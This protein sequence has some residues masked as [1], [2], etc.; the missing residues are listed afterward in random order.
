M[1]IP[2]NA[3]MTIRV[4]VLSA[5][6]LAELRAVEVQSHKTAMGVGAI[7]RQAQW[8]IPYLS[9]WGNQVQ[10]AGRQLIYNFTL[11]IALAIG[12]ATKFA[13]ENEKAM[14]R[15]IKVYGDG[16]KQFNKLSK[17][18]LPALADAFQALSNQFGVHQKEVLNIAGDWAAAGA[19]GIALAK[20]VKLTLE[21]MV[22]GEISAA[23]A[24]ENLIA[25][26][27]Q[28][29]QNTKELTNTID[30]LNMVENQTGA[31]MKG[32]MQAF[33]RSAGVARTAGVDVRHLGAMIAALVPATGSAATAGNGLK[34]MISRILSPTQEG[35][36]VM[37]EMGVQVDQLGWQSLNGTQRLEKMAE[38]FED[39]SDAQ[40]VHVSTV[41]ASRWQINRFATLMRDITNE[42]GYYQRSL[43]ATA[44]A[45]T[46]FNQRQFE[47]RKVLE[48]NPQRMQQAW[49][50]IKNAMADVIVPLL[51]FITYLA[52]EVARLANWFAN[53]DG[54]VQKFILVGFVFLALIGPIARYVGSVANLI[55][56]LSAAFHF[57]GAK[58][59]FML[60]PF[61]LF[62]K[63]VTSLGGPLKALPMLFAKS[64]GALINVFA[65][66]FTGMAF[67]KPWTM[68]WARITVVT[69]A[70]MAAIKKVMLAAVA[71]LRATMLAAWRGL[72]NPIIFA[73]A[74]MTQRLVWL[75]KLFQAAVL[76][77]F[78]GFRTVMIA[79]LMSFSAGLRAGFAAVQTAIGIGWVA[80][81]RSLVAAQAAAAMAIRVIHVGML[82]SG[83]ALVTGLTGVANA[84]LLIT[85]RA[86]IASLV[87]F[88]KI[89]ALIFMLWK[90]LGV[91][92]LRLA[93]FLLRALTGPWGLAI[94]AI[95]G[96]AY[97]FRDKIAAAW[98]SILEVFR[99][100][101][102]NVPAFF[103]PVIDFFNNMAG[104]I[105][106][107]FWALPEGVR[108]AL[109]A[110]LNIVKAAAVQIYE[111]MSYL[112]PFARHSPSLVESVTSGMD[113]IERQFAR[114]SSIGS[115]FR[116]AA[117][118]LMQFKREA[119]RGGEFADER[120]QVKQ[121]RGNVGLFDRLYVD[122]K[123]L[124]PIMQR[125]EMMVS[126][127]EAVVKRWEGAL[128]KAN[129]A[130]DRQ[131]AK[132][133]RLQ[134]H[135][136]KLQNQ[137]D[138]HKQSL[139]DFAN[140]PIK[141]MRAMENQIFA[142]ELAQKKLRLELLRYEEANGSVDDLR[143]RLDLLYG[144][145]ELLR[146]NAASLRSAGAGSD[147]LGPITSQI[148][149]MEAQAAALTKTINNNPVNDLQKQLEEL[150]LQGEIMDLEKSIKFDP[151][152]HE[153]DKLV[154]SQ[155]ELT[156]DQIIKG[157]NREQA[158]MDALQ[159]AIN[160]ATIAVNKQKNAVDQATAARDRIQKRYDTE[161]DK[162]DKL[163]ESYRQTESMV[164]DIE[165]ALRDM[166]SA[167][168]DAISKASGLGGG[169][170]P[171]GVQTFRAG[172]GADFADPGRFAQ[173][174]REGGMGNQADLINQFTEDTLGE[175]NSIF[176][177]FDMFGPIKRWWS[178]T[179][180]WLKENV[181]PVVGVVGDAI[182][183][184]WQQTVAGFNNVDWTP[185]TDT[186]KNVWNTVADIVRTGWGWIKAVID[187][188]APD[189]KRIFDA[190]IEAGKRLWEKLGPEL[191]KF[192]E[193]WEPLSIAI[194]NLW[195]ILKPVI[196]LFGIALV[197]AFKLVASVISHTLGP[198]LDF[199]VDMFVAVVRILRGVL[200]FII[201]VFAGD[202]KLA[203][204]GI[205]NIFGGIWDAIIATL[206]GAGKTLWGIVKGVVIGIWEFF[207]WL[208]RILVG[209][210]V[211]WDIVNGIFKAFN[212]LMKLPKWVWDNV[213]KPVWD[214][215]V[216][217]WRAIRDWFRTNGDIILGPIKTVVNAVIDA[218]NAMI[219]GMN[220][221]SDVLPGIDW[222]INLIP[223][224]AAGGELMSR[225][226]NRGFKTSGARAIVG[227][228]KANH[229]E[230]VIPTDPTHRQRALGL[231]SE[232]GKRMGVFDLPAFAGGGILDSIRGAVGTAKHLASE[233][234]DWIKGKVEN[235]ASV[236][237][238]FF[239]GQARKYIEQID[240]T[241][242]RKL[243]NFT[244]DEV[245]RWVTGADKVYADAANKVSPEVIAGKITK[246][247]WAHPL[248]G[249]YMIGGS[250]GSYPGHTG[251]DLAARLGTPV[252]AIQS[253]V[254]R[255]SQDLPGSN[256]YNSTPYRSYGRYIQVGHADGFL[257]L[258][259]HLNSRSV[260]PGQSVASGA[261]L[262]YVGTTGNST[263]P[264]LHLE[265]TK[266]G[267]LIE[268][269]NFLRNVGIPLST[270]GVIRRTS[271]GVL[272][273]LGEGHN[274]EVVAPL[275]RNWR[276]NGFGSSVN[277]D[278]YHI[279][280][281]GNLEFPNI[282]DGSDAE[283]FIENLIILAK[284]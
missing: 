188:F 149:A 57:L 200:Q 272:T 25:I 72:I 196:A 80:F 24:T 8:G 110:V 256:P 260:R 20:S 142:N 49:V 201:G 28:Y 106:N 103:R 243:A 86:A 78:L 122:L 36:D 11:P 242:A 247:G 56:L 124:Q 66:L 284:D 27:A 22:L 210:S 95:L 135:L 234:T 175:M 139:Q 120:K 77:A 33:A 111:W 257:S 173:I 235:L 245:K 112:N 116:R 5:K 202:W 38:A 127:Q 144:D 254:V 42:N 195:Q 266:N 31:S 151:M 39:L 237:F 45:Q 94:T 140:A 280:I 70:G 273:R 9:K 85:R 169:M 41:M 101:A 7:G 147:V 277:G 32:L 93:P 176:G 3:L 99:N 53:L 55:G 4:N 131:Q 222:E 148:A 126:S 16:S 261:L 208:F 275:P 265:I 46:V 18:E 192:K 91:A 141:G 84:A 241:Y 65:K 270:G 238:K 283:E 153:I 227:E 190:I 214:K 10:W 215:F 40:K 253:G 246:T 168:Q 154:N 75:W 251:L 179:W 50:I 63:G 207:V 181:G 76:Q 226:A 225:S 197:F 259:A 170:I 267:S 269:L 81:Q 221:I 19:S 47:L 58:F 211:V 118:D 230:F 79:A 1:V 213:L 119:G 150:Q 163:Q 102:N 171:V 264:H 48:S 6:A 262:G 14:V 87:V 172:V 157:I 90:G 187:L 258:Y 239:E 183:T 252:R 54:E 108:N 136:D 121:A 134:G 255:V 212:V 250:L 193:L 107:A 184:A 203:W 206:K 52:S 73:W 162:L 159:P 155:K 145:I 244:L 233:G 109:L 178:R 2:V 161:R 219:K 218:I 68:M 185:F 166:G 132:L 129:T 34:T 117:K 12:A 35:V 174:G 263:G 104:R 23:E 26:Q 114:A 137:Y 189:F 186:V 143:S 125:Q 182:R 62:S 160:R 61:A 69:G 248:F 123:A 96:I 82:A 217:A 249:P 74:T 51:P 177:G 165:S 204:R 92:L 281:T 205:K 232:A 100:S 276:Q 146:G 223:R 180:A 231:L 97:A 17:T 88:T 194:G 268:P 13:L 138:A 29:G 15:V 152:I 191:E 228:G 133:E 98:T 236:P 128:D 198:V 67:V 30:V 115:I 229:P 216:E 167:A 89:P 282:T 83:R 209:N 59:L 199:I 158:A 130:L 44:D 224:L 240:W 274:D 271:G 71:P 43:D 60:K 21:T 113:V 279:T 278:T 220:K 164:R 64:G 105:T 156:F 37:R